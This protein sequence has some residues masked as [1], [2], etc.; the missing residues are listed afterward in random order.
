M[1]HRSANESVLRNVDTGVTRRRFIVGTAAT[2]G[3]S[4]GGMVTTRVGAAPPP[5]YSLR[6]DGFITSPKDQ[7]I[8]VTCNSCTAFA[9]VAAVEGAYNKLKRLPGTNGPNLDEL[10][11]FKNAGPTEGCATTHWW[12]KFAL[13]YCQNPGLK[14]EGSSN[15][16]IKIK[17]PVDL[18]NDTNLNKTQDNMKDWIF[19]HGPVIAVMVQYEDFFAFGDSY[20]QCNGAGENTDVYGPAK[21]R[22]RKPGVIVGGHTLAVVGYQAN[23]YWICKNS[24]GDTWNGDGYVNIAQG[25]ANGL[26]ETYI[27][28]IDVWGVEVMS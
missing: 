4:A 12:P 25:T 21:R 18:L 20:F 6:R 11:L 8:P 2:V 22:N 19:N 5:S 28:R 7:D 10:D 24:W 17:P 3:G 26:G 16:P 23:D 9:V 14:W 13:G 15:Q 27:D 1:I